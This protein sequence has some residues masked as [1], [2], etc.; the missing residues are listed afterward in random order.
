[1]APRCLALSFLASALVSIVGCGGAPA[2]QA[3]TATQG[4][5]ADEG[6]AP[7]ASLGQTEKR[8]QGKWEIVKYSLFS[9]SLVRTPYS[10]CSE[11]VSGGTVLMALL[12]DGPLEVDCSE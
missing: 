11:L 2:A 5:A 3:T 8:L 1:M 9:R 4:S 12:I 6:A 10:V 7:D